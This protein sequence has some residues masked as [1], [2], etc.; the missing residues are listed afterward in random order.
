MRG[1]SSVMW[2][3]NNFENNTPA[4]YL[5]SEGVCN[6]HYVIVIVILI[7]IMFT[8]VATSNM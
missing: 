4:G 6:N 2:E 3:G 5:V 8:L 1:L 7:T